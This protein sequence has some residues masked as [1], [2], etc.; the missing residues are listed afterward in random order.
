MLILEIGRDEYYDEEKEMFIV[1]KKTKLQLE[2]SLVSI[3]KWEAN[4][5]TAFL[6]N[7]EKTLEQSIDYIR[8]MT[9]HGDKDPTVYDHI[10]TAQLEEVQAYITKKMT[11]TTITSRGPKRPG[12]K[13]ITS[14]VI[15]YWMTVHGIPF[16]PC[17][18]WHLNRLLML[19]EVASAENGPK[20]KMSRREQMAQQRALNMSRCAKLGTRG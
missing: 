8:C 14:E 2:H 10:T 20:E 18:K 3:S 6:S 9:I 1:G 17:E 5:E 7:T 12:R 15:Y 13:I 16:D 19:I 4:W 11:A